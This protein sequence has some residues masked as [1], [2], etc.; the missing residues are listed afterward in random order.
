MALH[1]ELGRRGEQIAQEFLQHSGYR[2]LKINWK[3]GR[4]EVDVI[5]DHDGVIVF[6]EVK[7]RSS[8]DFGEPEEFVGRKKE[9]QLEFASSAYLE[10]TGH[11]GEIRFDIIAIVFENK[12]LYKIN[13]IEDAFWPS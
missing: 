3:Y 4:A 13:H 6:V 8:R 9:R 2:I 11:Q 5:A 1:N 10:M 12:D 7:T